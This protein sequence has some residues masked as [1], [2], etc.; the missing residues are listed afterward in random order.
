M[1]SRRGPPVAGTENEIPR[2]GKDDSKNSPSSS[3]RRAIWRRSSTRASRSSPSS[4]ASSRA[5]SWRSSNSGI[6]RILPAHGAP[7]THYGGGHPQRLLDRDLG[8]ALDPGRGKDDP[9]GRRV[10]PAALGGRAEEHPDRPA[11]VGDHQRP[12]RQL[13]RAPL[14]GLAGARIADSQQPLELLGVEGANRDSG[15]DDRDRQRVIEVVAALEAA[16]LD[17][18][19]REL[20]DRRAIAI[21]VEPDLA[22]EDPVG[23]GDRPLA[24]VDRVAAGEPVGELTKP[25]LHGPRAAA[26][27]PLDLQARQ[28]EPRELGPNRGGDPAGIGGV[29]HLRRAPRPWR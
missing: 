11:L 15:L 3:S 26:G 27:G 13:A 7:D 6:T 29:V 8:H 10:D 19:V 28:S 1:P 5:V 17:P 25:V 20:L 9:S 2:P 24:Q 23:P 4:S 21:R 16:R 22:K 18:V 12:L 14:Q